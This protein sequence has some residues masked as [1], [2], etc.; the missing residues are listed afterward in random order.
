M[1][2]IGEGELAGAGCAVGTLTTGVGLGVG[3]LLIVGFG[4]AERVPDA[5]GPGAAGTPPPPLTPPEGAEV[6][7][8]FGDAAAETDGEDLLVGVGLTADPFGEEGD[9][10]GEEEADPDFGVSSGAAT[11]VILVRFR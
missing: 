2:A 8:V 1:V 9:E 3:A 4:E 6:L 7:V 10:V 11:R 5:V